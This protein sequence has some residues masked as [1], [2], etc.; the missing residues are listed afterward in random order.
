MMKT[1]FAYVGLLVIAQTASFS[2]GSDLMQVSALMQASA[3]MQVSHS[4]QASASSTQSSQAQPSAKS[5]APAAATQVAAPAAVPQSAAELPACLT[6]T[7][8][9]GEWNKAR[10]DE[11]L[12]RVREAKSPTPVVF[13]G[14]SITE[15]WESAG[16]KIWA[17]DFAP[18]GALNLGVGGARTEHILWRL[19]QAPLT[20]L[21]PRVV[22]LMI[23]TN[24]VV[25][26][27]DSGEL[28]VRGIRAIVQMIQQQCP[29]AKVLVLDITPRG[30]NMNPV[31]GTVTQI[32]QVLGQIAWP[33]GVVALRVGDRFVQSDGSIHAEIMPDFLHFSAAGYEMW[34][35]GIKPAVVS[36]LLPAQTAL[37][38][39][40]A[41]QPVAETV[42]PAAHASE[43]PVVP[44]ATNHPR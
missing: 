39:S 9:D 3:C 41:Q 10:Q 33:E 14:D 26:G 37:P 20:A 12:R 1:R 34:S 44:P 43:V 8:Q 31:R 19:Q 42:K 16:A 2:Q 7:S 18:L 23:G 27:R 30:V 24:N 28:I 38:K 35:E 11:V 40:S 13:I 5:Q 4:M 6:P 36:A 22:V 21:D 25:S 32:N 17:R 29:K 15:Q